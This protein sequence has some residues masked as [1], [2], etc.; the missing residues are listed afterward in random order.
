M[1][2]IGFEEQLKQEEIQKLKEEESKDKTYKDEDGTE[3]E[4]DEAKK[5]WFPKISEDFIAQYQM[6]YGAHSADPQNGDQQSADQ[7]K[8][9][10]DG[11][12][13]DK[14]VPSLEGL[15]VNSEEYA[16]RYHEYYAYYYGEDYANYY[17]YYNQE[18][19]QGEVQA[20]G[21]GN[22][23]GQDGNQKGKKRKKKGEKPDPPPKREEGWFEVEE[24]KNTNVYVSGLPEDVTEEEYKTLMNR[25]GLVMF[26]PVMKQ[27]KLKLY[28][29]E[30]GNPKGDG[31]CCYIKT[32]SV[33]LA[34]KFL[35]GSDVRGS[36]IHVERAQFALKGQFDP[37]KKKKK[38]SNKQKRKFLE[39]QKKLFDWRPELKLEPVTRPKNEKVVVLK[40]MFSPK[41]FEADP[42]LINELRDDTR[43]ECSK[44]GEVK[45]IRLYDN[46]PD[47]VI[48]VT[49]KTPCEADEVIKLLNGRWFAKKQIT[50]ESWDGK[51][52]YD[53]EESEAE[54]DE[55]LK[56]WG[57][58]L[59]KDE[60]SQSSNNI[61]NTS[62]ESADSKA[63]VNSSLESQTS[64]ESLTSVEEV[65]KGDKSN[66]VVTSDKIS[67][68]SKQDKIS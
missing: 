36:T 8:E 11:E 66:N 22:S 28:L 68:V 67:S 10:K 13:E 26:D 65:D 59:E 14:G 47:G 37:A 62:A 55:R 30:H 61:T 32:E 19:V 51:T 21:Q 52:K 43:T 6:T 63:S 23:E 3:Y 17:S 60:Q 48:T 50:A 44:L 12:S 34:L 25:C 42:M 1:E 41:E 53:I 9:E 40:N 18:E 2:D 20:E 7:N 38:L 29:N 64:Q 27:P 49:M 39:K 57:E 31:R 15:D 4:W 58:F 45:N 5:A 35:D 54:R 16:K 46:H 24:D 56:K 33:E